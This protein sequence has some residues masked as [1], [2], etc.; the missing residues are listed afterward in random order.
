[1]CLDTEHGET[2]GRE[3]EKNN[4]RSRPLVAMCQMLIVCVSLTSR[5]SRRVAMIVLPIHHLLQTAPLSTRTR[6]AGTTRHEILRFESVPRWAIY[7]VHSLRE[8]EQ[9]QPPTAMSPNAAPLQSPF[10]DACAS[11]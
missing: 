8:D 2:N 10:S 4:Q 6:G 5:D 3:R 11:F 7:A 1:M 9:K